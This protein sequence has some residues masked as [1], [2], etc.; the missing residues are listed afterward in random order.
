VLKVGNLTVGFGASDDEI[1]PE[2]FFG[3][4]LGDHLDEQVLLVKVTQGN[5]SLAVEG[6]P[7]SSGGPTGPYYRYMLATFREAL[8]TLQQYFP[9]YDGRGYE[10]AGF[11]W[12][13]GWNDMTSPNNAAQYQFNLT[14]LIRDV[15]RDLGV[16]NL[17]VVVGELGVGGPN[18]DPPIAAFRKAQAG[19][20]GRPEFAGTVALAKTADFWDAEAEAIMKKGWDPRSR[21]WTDP[22]LQK[23]FDQMGSDEA[24]HYLGSGKILSLV[25][26]SL[27]ESMKKLPPP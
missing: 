17:P 20:T 2:L 14:N 5:L 4:V 22:D 9:A 19:A 25:G 26:Y 13:Q 6:R 10:V 21:K 27:G 15:R 11:V 18:P 7:P 12:F 3:H 1:G 8:G 16:P 24:Y 23:R